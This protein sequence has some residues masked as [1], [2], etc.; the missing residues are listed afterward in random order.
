MIYLESI[1]LILKI[2]SFFLSVETLGGIYVSFL[3]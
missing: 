1:E 2:N 3:Q